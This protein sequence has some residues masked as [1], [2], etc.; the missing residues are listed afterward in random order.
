MSRV[1][2]KSC[3]G[4]ARTIN[5]RVKVSCV[6]AYTTRHQGRREPP[7][8]TDLSGHSKTREHIEMCQHKLIEFINGAAVLN[9]LTILACPMGFLRSAA[10][11]VPFSLSFAAFFTL[12]ISVFIVIFHHGIHGNHLFKYGSRRR[13]RKGFLLK[14]YNRATHSYTVHKSPA[15]RLI[16]QTIPHCRARARHHQA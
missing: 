6:A 4:W 3:R 11:D 8:L 7:F 12:H 2:S 14:K 15:C 5:E 10:T 1:L 13:K 16:W 9:G